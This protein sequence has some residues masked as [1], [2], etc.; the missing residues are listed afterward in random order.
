MVPFGIG[1]PQMTTCCFVTHTEYK[2]GQQAPAAS[3]ILIPRLKE[4][5]E[6]AAV[7]LLLLQLRSFQGDPLMQDQSEFRGMTCSKFSF[8]K[9]SKD[10][11]QI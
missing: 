4:H 3:L 5:G 8:V 9:D 11:R 10:T 7:I 1:G 6:R 2:T